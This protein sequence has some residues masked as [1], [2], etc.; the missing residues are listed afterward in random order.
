MSDTPRDGDAERLAGWYWVLL[1]NH[2]PWY[3]YRWKIG[4]N[5]A[6]GWWVGLDER[7]QPVE[8]GPPIPGPEE[9]D[10]RDAALREKDA[11]IIAHEQEILALRSR[12]DGA[13]SQIARLRA[14]QPA[15][16][17]AAERAAIVAN[18]KRFESDRMDK[19]KQE[20]AEGGDPAEAEAFWNQVIAARMIRKRIE[21][22]EHAQPRGSDNG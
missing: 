17:A 4:R 13:L 9:L 7:S 18:I 20:E 2:E 14:A 5:S 12:L 1:S 22:G 10:A 11:E 15:P 3:P 16:D 21:R 19:K 6:R 8:V